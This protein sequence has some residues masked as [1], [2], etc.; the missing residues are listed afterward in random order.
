MPVEVV[1]ARSYRMVVRGSAWRAAIWTSRRLMPASS[2]V[3]TNVCRSMCGCM[4]GIRTPAVAARCLSLRVAAWRSIRVPSVL[5][6]IG[7]SV[8]VGLVNPVWLRCLRVFVD[9]SADGRAPL[10]P[11]GVEVD[12]LRWRVGW[13]LVE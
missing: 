10:D 11:R 2:I 5:R 4:R 3:V 12:D 7:P 8:R 9:Q 13:S 6:R 1:A